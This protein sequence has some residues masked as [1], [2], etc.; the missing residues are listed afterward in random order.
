FGWRANLCARKGPLTAVDHARDI[1][2]QDPNLDFV[3]FS[4]VVLPEARPPD[5]EVARTL[6]TRVDWLAERM[7]SAPIP[8]IPVGSTCVNVSDYGRELLT[9]LALLFLSRLHPRMYTLSHP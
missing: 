8:V 1:A 2:V 6:E 4:G 7:G 9:P 3:V 5:E